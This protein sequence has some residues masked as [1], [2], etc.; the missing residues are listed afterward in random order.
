MISP[1]GA[2]FMNPTLDSLRDLY[3]SASS[4]DPLSYMTSAVALRVLS[5]YSQFEDARG[6]AAASYAKA[7]RS[8]SAAI[9]DENK[10][11]NN[12]TLMAIMLGVLY[13]V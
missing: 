7:L 5:N 2:K 13:E 4:S 9:E 6:R 1:A 10:A 3:P 12:G 8:I 11:R